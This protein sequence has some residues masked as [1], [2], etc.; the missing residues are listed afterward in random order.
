VAPTLG[1]IIDKMVRFDFRQR[2][3]SVKEVL[4]A[5][6]PL[7][8]RSTANTIISIA[9]PLIDNLSA[10]SVALENI[11]DIHKSHIDRLIDDISDDLEMSEDPVRV[12]KLICL[13]CTGILENDL[14]RLNNFSFGE[15]L[16]DLYQQYS[17]IKSIKD[18]LVNGVKTIAI[19][20]QRQYLMIAKLVFDTI[21]KLYEPLPTPP[22]QIIS[23]SQFHPQNSTFKNISSPN[24]L[25]QVEYSV[26]HLVINAGSAQ[27]VAPINDHNDINDQ[28]SNED[29]DIYTWVAN[30][31]DIDPQQMRLKK[32]LLYTY[33]NVWESDLR[34]LNNVDWSR[35]LRELVS[36]MPTFSQMQS[37]LQEAIYKVSKPSEYAIIGSLLLTKLEA[38]YPDHEQQYYSA[39]AASPDLNEPNLD[40]DLNLDSDFNNSNNNSNN[41]YIQNKIPFDLEIISNLFDVRLELMRFA[42]SMRTKILLF[43]LLYY[44]FDPDRDNWQ[45]V[46]AHKLDQLLR[47]IFYAYPAFDQAEPQIWRMARSLSE[48][49][50]YDQSASYILKTLKTL[51]DL[52]EAKSMLHPAEGGLP[53]S[54]DQDFTQP[55]IF[56][57]D[58]DTCQF[59]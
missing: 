58:D 42:N 24:L 5:L 37:L 48:P 53:M 46:K 30:E 59:A 1:D 7:L 13:V 6:E 11:E 44:P 8:M 50:A 33:Q 17:T 18:S 40:A 55:T 45:D 38:L 23:E 54:D 3:Q 26:N 2:Y 22:Q 47:Q 32:L 31:I 36:F 51:Y 12:K 4:I 43:S 27:L 34:Q 10:S 9:N 16:H 49:N 35:L 56:R 21:S 52:L 41:N 39:I 15:L 14:E 29:S 20:K 57:S 28:N 25:S 19:Q